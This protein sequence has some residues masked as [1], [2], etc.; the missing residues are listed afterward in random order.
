[1]AP[2]PGREATGRAVPASG[3]PGGVQRREAAE[4]RGRRDAGQ[5]GR[6]S[7]AN[8]RRSLTRAARIARRP[9]AC[10]APVPQPVPMPMPGPVPIPRS[11]SPLN[12]AG[13]NR[14][15]PFGTI[16]LFR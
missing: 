6:Q 12:R 7:M 1:M 11:V 9:A 16:P 15:L 10:S 2:R 14:R 5:R 4:E 8:T 3:H 13:L